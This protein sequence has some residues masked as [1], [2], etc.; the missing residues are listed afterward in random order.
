MQ[1]NGIEVKTADG[2]LTAFIKRS[3]LSRDRSEQRPERFNVGDK[4]DAFVTSADKAARRLSLSIK[5]LEI[6]EEKQAVAQYGSSDSGASLGD[7]FKAAI[8]KR[9]ND[10]AEDE[11][12]DEQ[13]IS[14]R[15]IPAVTTTRR[16]GAKPRRASILARLCRALLLSGAQTLPNVAERSRLARL[17]GR[18]ADMTAEIDTVLD[19][20]RLRRR[21]TV[22]R[23]LAVAA[24]VAA[25]FAFG[26]SDDKLSS[27]GPKQIAR[28]AIE[29]TI[30][31]DREQLELLKRIA[32]ADN[33]AA[34]LVFVNSPGGTT[35]GGEALFAALREVAKKKPVVA[36]FGTVAA[37]AGYIVGLGADHIVTRANTITGSV[38]VLIQWPEVSQALDKLGVKFNEI[39]SGDLK[40]VPV[41]LR[42]PQRGG[43]EGH[44]GDDRRGLPLVP[45][46]RRAAPR[47]QG[48]TR[49]PG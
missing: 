40:A 46:P 4:V 3:D 8:R 1:E 47:H 11:K 45:R 20:R 27:F 38:G 13:G 37:S 10:G 24:V 2:E 19:R 31:E 43:P 48:R 15:L 7:I 23:A 44:P 29:G 35:T 22:W 5:A 30:T 25:L 14:R 18:R 34:L 49:S 36:Q 26:V 16:G 41:A 32:E 17:H 39:K 6:A 42:A 12:A 9:E 28:V 33:A 21:L